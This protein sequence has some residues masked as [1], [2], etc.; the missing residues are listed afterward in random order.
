MCRLFGNKFSWQI[1]CQESIQKENKP[2]K[3]SQF[4]Q[5][6]LLLPFSLKIPAKANNELAKRRG[7]CAVLKYY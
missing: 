5:N 3:S 4:M 1:K 2:V 6:F 7:M